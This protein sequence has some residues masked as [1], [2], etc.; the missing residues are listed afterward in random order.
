MERLHPR[1][2]AGCTHSHP[3]ARRAANSEV[4]PRRPQGRRVGGDVLAPHSSAK[5]IH[6][7]RGFQRAL[8]AG[9]RTWVRHRSI[10]SS[11]R[12]AARVVGTWWEKPMRLSRRHTP[13]GSA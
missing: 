5:V 7:L 1:P 10:S 6:A 13:E 2:M 12:S 8:L 3:A 9:G 11:S 4:R